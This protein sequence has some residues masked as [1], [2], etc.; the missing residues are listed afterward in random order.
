MTAFP[1]WGGGDPWGGSAGSATIVVSPN[2]NPPVVS[3]FTPAEGTPV[4]ANTPIGF[5]V[6]DDQDSFRRIMV[7][8]AFANLGVTEVVFDGENFVG[9]FASLSTRLSING[10]YRFAIQRQGG[11]IGSPEIKVIA[12]DTSGNEGT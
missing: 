1:G 4:S 5:D 7:T 9:R 2:P 11:W 12:I 6:T 10:G 8:A 3:N